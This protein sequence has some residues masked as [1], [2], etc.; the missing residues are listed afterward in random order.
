[1]IDEITA[2]I[3][4]VMIN[5]FEDEVMGMKYLPL[6][7]IFVYKKKEATSNLLQLMIAF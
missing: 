5:L 4:L 1:M 7:K 3:S 6:V 2:I